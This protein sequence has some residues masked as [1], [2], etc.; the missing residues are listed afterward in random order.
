MV[1]RV[2]Q[3]VFGRGLVATPDDFGHLGEQPTHPELLDHLALRFIDDGWSVKQLVRSL[4]LSR[5]FR[6]ASRPTDRPRRAIRS[7]ELLSHYSARRGEA[8]VIRDSLLAVSGGSIPSC[9]GRA[10]ILTARRPTRTSGCSP[11][12]STGLG[13]GASTSSSSLM[14]APDFL[15]AF[16]LPGGKVTQGPSRSLE[17]PSPAVALLNDRSCWRWPDHWAGEL[18][19]DGSPSVSA[20]VE[21]MFHKALGR[22]PS[23]PERERFEQAIRSMAT[24]AGVSEADLLTTARSGRTRRIWCSI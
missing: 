23:T 10:C 17:H 1:N 2:W 3:W 11:G 24:Q 18:I 8:E 21:A 16:N 14:E 4:V 5:A 9:S 15:S 13:G 6:T 19:A 12:R 20:R 22:S 7:I